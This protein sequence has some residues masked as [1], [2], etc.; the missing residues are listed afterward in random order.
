M[1]NLLFHV[2]FLR[3]QIKIDDSLFSLCCQKIFKGY[4]TNSK[5]IGFNLV[6]TRNRNECL[7]W[8]KIFSSGFNKVN[9]IFRAGD[10]T[11]PASHAFC[12]IYKAF[13]SFYILPGNGIKVA[14]LVAGSTPAA[15]A[16]G[17]FGTETAWINHTNA[18]LDQNGHS[19][20][21]TRTT[22]ADEIIY[23]MTIHSDM[24]EPLFLCLPQN[25]E[26]FL[27]IY[28]SP[29]ASGESIIRSLIDLNAG[30][31]GVIAFSGCE[32]TCTV[33]YSQVFGVF[34]NLTDTLKVKDLCLGLD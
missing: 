6:E 25:I 21:T 8:H 32:P 26:S 14:A 5:P 7:S 11:Q 19:L 27:G 33:R 10:H 30:L 4:W 3:G 17:N 29:G 31:Q 15:Q 22:V 1:P 9:S 28:L 18:A 20:A 13:A 23:L 16:A 2:R 34:H 24:D 12:C